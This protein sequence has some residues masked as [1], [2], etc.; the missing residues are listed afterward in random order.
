MFD[1]LN[2]D[3]EILFAIYFSLRV[4]LC[5]VLILSP[6]ALILAKLLT[7]LNK[8]WLAICESIIYL[9]LVM[10]PVAIGYVL[11]LILKNFNGLVFSFWAALFAAI[12]VSLPLYVSNIYVALKNKSKK[13]EELAH[14]LGVRRHMI[15]LRVTVP[16]IWPGILSGAILTFIRSVGEFGATI[17][18][19][20]NIPGVTQSLS[21]AMWTALQQPEGEAKAFGL[22]LISIG[23]GV[24]AIFSSVYFQKF[25]S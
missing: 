22:L 21:G 12:I 11:L 19:A 4:G 13:P 3:H 15:F 17:V 6:I 1:L 8:F 9:P 10:P 7:K 2:Y 20:G 23:L 5:S 18:V 16:L 14:S 24:T 25:L